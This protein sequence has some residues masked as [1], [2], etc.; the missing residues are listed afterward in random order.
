MIGKQTKKPLAKLDTRAYLR[1]S[2]DEMKRWNRCANSMG[3]KFSRFM[4]DACEA[5]YRK[6]IDARLK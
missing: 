6:Q 3:I 5:Y 2:K 1:L 4:R